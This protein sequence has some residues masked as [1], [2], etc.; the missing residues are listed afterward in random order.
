MATDYE[1]NLGVTEAFI[2]VR[3]QCPMGSVRRVAMQA[4]E[5]AGNGGAGVLREQAYFVLTAIQGWRGERSQQVH[6]S[7]QAFLDSG[8]KPTS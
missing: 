7:L 8:S 2:A 5:A 4:I 3:D 6:R 1:R